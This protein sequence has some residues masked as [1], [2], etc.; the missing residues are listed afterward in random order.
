MKSSSVISVF[1]HP[2]TAVVLSI[3]LTV[4]L[5]ISG[6]KEDLVVEI[7]LATG[8]VVIPTV[9][10]D[11]FGDILSVEAPVSKLLVMISVGMILSAAEAVE[12]A[13]FVW[14][15]RLVISLGVVMVSFDLVA[16]SSVPKC[17]SVITSGKKGVSVVVPG[18][19]GVVESVRVP[20]PILI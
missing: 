3:I 7:N 11:F 12:C 10:S 13:F 2:V 1:F 5:V 15:S 18:F 8:V 9:E 4:S 6:S 14:I 16:L 17:S 19:V 20:I